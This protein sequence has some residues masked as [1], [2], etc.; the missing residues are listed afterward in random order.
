[1]QAIKR[2]KTH[3]QGLD[4]QMEG[5]IPEGS[6]VMVMGTPGTMKSTF[7]FSMLYHNAVED[8]V[9]GM[10]LTL[11]Q[12]ESSL[13]MQMARLGMDPKDVEDWISILDIGAVRQESGGRDPLGGWLPVIKQMITQVREQLGCEVLVLDSLDAYELLSAAPLGRGELFSFFEWLRTL[14]ITT[15]LIGEVGPD[16]NPYGRH[17]EGFLADGIILLKMVDIGEIDVQ[18]RLRV[19]KMR[20]T[21]HHPGYFNLLI[22]GDRFQ[23]TKAIVD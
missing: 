12:N 22:E 5:G 17:S 1:M 15:L 3:V 9:K 11:E 21:K 6:I 23:V 4:E 18:R 14:K 13:S 16:G 19:M 2:Y 20:G 8:N 10:Y 7:T